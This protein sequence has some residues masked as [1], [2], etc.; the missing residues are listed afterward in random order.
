MTAT[1]EPLRVA[2]RGRVLCDDAALVTSDGGEHPLFLTL[3]RPP[4]VGARLRVEAPDG[5]AWTLE[6]RRTAEVAAAGPRG[7]RGC[8]VRALDEGDAG[9]A[10]AWVGSE[11]L[12]SGSAPTCH[13]RVI[14]GAG[15]V[16]TPPGASVVVLG[17]RGAA[18]GVKARRGRIRG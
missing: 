12:T 15:E 14:P 13:L 6:V 2:L 5:R 9:D 11:H 4:P 8:W 17:R 16:T 3:E 7:R 10:A 1:H 18:P